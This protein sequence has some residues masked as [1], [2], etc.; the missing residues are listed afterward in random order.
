MI[1]EAVCVPVCRETE[2]ESEKVE[3]EK[4]ALILGVLR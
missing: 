2:G 3:K 4:A 1:Y